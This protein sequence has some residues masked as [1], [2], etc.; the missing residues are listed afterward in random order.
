MMREVSMKS[1]WDTH[2]GVRFFYFDLSGFGDDDK[3]VIE[4]C[5]KAD[6]VLMAEPEDS[7]LI[8]NDVRNSVGSLDVIKHLQLSADRSSPY[9]KRAAVV[10]VTGPKLILLQL[11]NRFSRHPIVHFDD[12]EQAKDWLVTNEIP[13]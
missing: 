8:L 4:E 12:F 10:G 13:E 7:I 6:A 9:I 3:G 1:H 5:D 11:V 2:R